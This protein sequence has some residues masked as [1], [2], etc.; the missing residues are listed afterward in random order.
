MRFHTSQ[1]ASYNDYVEE[2]RQREYPMI[3]G[4]TYLDHAGTTLYSKSLM[5]RF[6]S[7]M[8][9]N[10]FGNPHSASSSSIASSRRVDDVRL[11]LLRHFNADPSEFDVVFVANATAAV[12]L[13]IEAFRNADGGYWYGYHRD[14]HTSL[15][16]ARESA[17]SHTCFGS[18]DEVGRWIEGGCKTE[19]GKVGLF[20][21]PA[22]SNM[23]GRRLPLEWS[24]QVRSHS[25]SSNST[26]YSLLDAAALVSTT[27]LDLSDPEFAT[28]FTAVSLY[29][30]FGFPDLGAL[31][32]RR[33][34]GEVFQGRQYFGG[35]TVDMV[36]CV[37][38]QWYAR[39][40]ETLHDQL[41][42]GTL[43][44]HSIV[45][46]GLALVLHEEL[47]GSFDKIS[48]HTSSLANRLYSGLTSMKHGNGVPACEVYKDPAA[49]YG[50]SRTQGAIVAF[51][52]RNSQYGWVSNSEVEKLASI[53][54]IHIR[55]GGLCN[56]GGIASSLGLAP[57]EMRENF[58]A[59]QRCGEENDIRSGKPTGMIRASLGA[60]STVSDV[61]AFLA[62]IREFFVEGTTQPEHAIARVD[63]PLSSVPFHVESL[64]IYPIKSCAGWKIAASKPWEVRKE[65]LAWDREWCLVHQGT[66]MALTQKRYPRMALLR[67]SID[68]E[69]G[70]L[71]VRVVG[72]APTGSRQREVAVPL[73]WDPS[74]FLSDQELQHQMARVC[75]DKINAHTYKSA[76]TAEFFSDTLGVPC[77]LARFPLMGTPS[78]GGRHSKAHIQPYQNRAVGALGTSSSSD[79]EVSPA[80]PQPIKL[81]NESPILVISRS[82]LNRLNEHIKASGGKAAQAEVFRANIVL[83]ENME[84][85]PGAEQPYIE[86]QWRSAL[87]GQRRFRMLGSCRRCQMVCV[88][89]D[90]AVKNEEPFV[91]LS[92]TRRFDG[93][94]FFGQHACYVH[95]GRDRA[96][97]ADQFPTI[98]VGDSAWPSA[99]P[100]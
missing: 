95:A 42:D 41:E 55:T 24:S 2:M 77:Q 16:G 82:S 63:S 58:S 20:S 14:S 12:K 80:L 62:F 44:I 76:E 19:S 46:L 39:K 71:R 89:Q 61:D 9:S 1:E 45:A 99:E 74:Y 40:S 18:D 83:A 93:K 73:S 91:T 15:V 29:K 4:I 38:E 67:P 65:G 25:K 11:K 26:I 10:A 23:N 81:S 50:D 52:L 43:P 49:S 33:D 90:T 70:V 13:V 21:Y 85:F 75:G 86:D 37:K 96:G 84:S 87:I 64:T 3:K 57:W 92:K 31:I 66:G 35:G 6:S 88:D 60:M 28:D 8:V 32:V 5:E 36:V 68:L 7:E 30:I 100:V 47:F 27:T 72:S 97:P 17:K 48:K 69:G 59:G 94:V 56:P 34:A 79:A 51:N 22:Q 98:Q 78:G 53:K 54:N